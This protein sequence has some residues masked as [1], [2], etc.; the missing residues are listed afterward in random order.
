MSVQIDMQPWLIIALAPD[1][2]A[3]NS[4][5]RKGVRYSVA[6]AE[7]CPVHA[8]SETSSIVSPKA[9]MPGSTTAA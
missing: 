3:E 7:G 9:I 4:F 5:D 2:S 6:P 1:R 8:S